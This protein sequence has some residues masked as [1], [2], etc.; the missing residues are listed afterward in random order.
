MR[1]GPAVS[2]A[3]ATA[4]LG[5]ALAAIATESVKDLSS[6]LVELQE[7]QATLQ[8]T[9]AAK[10]SELLGSSPEWAQ[11]KLILDR[12]P[13]YRAKAERIRRSMAST[14]QRLE[15]VEKGSAGLRGK[16]EEKDRERSVKKSAD[17]AGFAAVAAR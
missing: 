13:E 3:D 15:K 4:A 6:R 9:I 7:S 12:V 2:T 1:A 10:S 8:S 14:L 17:S 16:L 11:A 5:N